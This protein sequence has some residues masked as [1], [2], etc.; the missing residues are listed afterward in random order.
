MRLDARK[1]LSAFVFFGTAAALVATSRPAKEHAHDELDQEFTLAAGE[2]RTYAVEFDFVNPGDARD[3]VSMNVEVIATA[4]DTDTMLTLSLSESRYEDDPAVAREDI[5]AD[6]IPVTIGRIWQSYSVESAPL[7]TLTMSED[8]G[9]EGSMN[10]SVSVLW[11][12][13]LE[14]T[15]TPMRISLREVTPEQDAD[16]TNR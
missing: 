13:E 9:A 8:G 12:P 16:E 4:T 11:G 2:S 1:S 10:V 5:R 14:D 3:Y 15:A 6:G 7:I